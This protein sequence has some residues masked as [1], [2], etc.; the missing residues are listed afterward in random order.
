MSVR[1]HRTF[2]YRKNT[3]SEMREDM[4]QAAIKFLRDDKVKSA[5]LAKKIAFLESKGLSSTE[6]ETAIQRATLSGDA[7]SAVSAPP[8]PSPVPVSPGIPANQAMIQ[9]PPLPYPI[10]KD[11]VL[12]LAGASAVVAT[13]WQLIKVCS[14]LA[15]RETRSSCKD[16]STSMDS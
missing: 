14:I 12:G 4:I 15:Y 10:W 9:P 8:V 2:A 13:V 1:N 5:P 11:V 16:L 6:I 7:S 3:M